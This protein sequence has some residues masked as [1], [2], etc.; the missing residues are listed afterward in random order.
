[1]HSDSRRPAGFTLYELIAVLFV[2]AIITAVALPR[3][4]D[5][6]T[7][8][9]VSARDSLIIHLRY[10]QAQ[11][12]GTEGVWG[13]EAQGGQY[14]LFQAPN[15]NTP[16][17]IVGQNDVQVASALVPDFTVSFDTLGRPYANAAAAGNTQ[18]VTV[19]FPGQVIVLTAETGF[20][21]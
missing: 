19:N 21:P 7:A 13:I 17:R 15:P 3:V 4:L 14:W 1:M 8:A 6:G 11:A 20:I 12:M 5:P 9:A 2:I 16:I 18:D 10:A